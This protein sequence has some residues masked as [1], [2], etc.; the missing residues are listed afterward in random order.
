MYWCRYSPVKMLF[1]IRGSIYAEKCKSN[2]FGIAEPSL[3]KNLAKLFVTWGK[4]N[5]ICQQNFYQKGWYER[6]VQNFKI[7]WFRIRNI[8]HMKWFSSVT[9]YSVSTS[10]VTIKNERVFWLKIKVS[11]SSCFHTY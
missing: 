4:F 8:A 9:A 1:G 3:K 5:H 2:H 10:K 6:D 11:I 7:E